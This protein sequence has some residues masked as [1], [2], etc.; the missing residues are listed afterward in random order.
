VAT[1]TTSTVICI[2]GSV[3]ATFNVSSNG[4]G[5]CTDNYQYTLTGAAPFFPYT[6]GASLTATSAGTNRIIIQ[7]S[8]TCAGNG[9]D[10]AGET[11]ATVAQWTV[12]ADPTITT[13]P[14]PSSTICSG[15]T[16][17]LTGVVTPVTGPVY[18]YQWEES[19]DNGV[20]D[21]WANAVGGSG[22]NTLSYTT[23][24]LTSTIYYRLYITST[25]NG[26]T[27]PII[28][29][30][31]LVTVVADPTAPNP[32]ITNAS[33]C[34]GGATVVA[35]LGSG[36]SGTILYQWQYNNGGT[37]ANVVNATPVGFTYGTPTATSMT[38]TTANGVT[39]PTGT[40]QFRV[41]VYTATS[42]CETFSNAV[43]FTVASDPTAPTLNVASPGSGTSICIGDQVSATFN[44]SS[45]GT[46]VCTDNYQY[47]LTGAAPFTAY[48]PGA[49]LTATSAGTNRIIIQTSRTCAGNGCDGTGETFATVAQWT[50]LTAITGGSFV[51][52]NPISCTTSNGT[53]TVTAPTGG[54]GTYNY[55]RTSTNGSNGT[56]QASTSF[57]GIA[58]G[59]SGTVW[60]RNSVAP[61]CPISLGTYNMQEPY[62]P[63]AAPTAA[64]NISNLCSS[65]I[66]TLTASGLEP[67]SGGSNSVVHT[68]T[69]EQTSII[70]MQLLP[71]SLPE[72]L[73]PLKHG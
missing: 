47:T 13:H 50:V 65:N 40:F 49:L 35:S 20:G 8:R 56:W 22:A 70:T 41:R 33:V 59:A 38:I 6:P 39:T 62:E 44:L 30:S 34:R 25:S 52:T 63:I 51:Y 15:G 42:G 14:T 26:C 21:A 12:A 23:P 31:A 45:N 7:T 24:A 53:I 19:N 64:S 18:A 48:T 55:S 46:G 57:T 71:D 58:D 54:S 37:W 73:Q 68:V 10:G 43:D 9:C 16:V 29:N 11:F 72:V 17:T 67:G 32:S 61:Y 66:A 36:G 4:T 27:T 1:P 5:V 28:S 60:V 3:S 2:G 69:M